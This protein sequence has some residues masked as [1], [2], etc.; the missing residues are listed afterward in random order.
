MIVGFQPETSWVAKVGA[1]QFL[2]VQWS[3]SE[4]SF[5][6]RPLEQCKGCSTNALSTP[7][8]E[9]SLAYPSGRTRRLRIRW[10]K[11]R[12]T[13]GAVTLWKREL[14]VNF[15]TLYPASYIQARRESKR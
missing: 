10:T 9:S 4:L 1:P 11:C 6:S 7:P 8:L 5:L 12:F 15:A 2:T 3:G 14:N 13:A